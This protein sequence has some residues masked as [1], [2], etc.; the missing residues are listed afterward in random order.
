MSQMV[1]NIDVQLV[2]NHNPKMLIYKIFSKNLTD[3]NILS[4][5]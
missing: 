3:L 5:W 2:K 4:T 1:I